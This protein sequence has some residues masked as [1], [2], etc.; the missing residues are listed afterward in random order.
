MKT[1]IKQSRVPRA[2]FTAILTASFFVTGCSMVK[3]ESDV[4]GEYELR[5]ANGKIVLTVLPD[6]SFS[7]MIVWPTGKVEN[8]SGKWLWT[9][10][11]ISFDQLWIPSEF[12]PEFILQADAEAKANKQPKYTEPGHWSMRAEKHWRTVTLPIFP[13]ADV[14]FKM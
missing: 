2:V 11:G 7:E 5:A 6:R 4:L 10:N 3:S 13:D 1:S 8:R 9:E 12:A 14:S